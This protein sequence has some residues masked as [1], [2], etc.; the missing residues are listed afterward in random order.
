MFEG[1]LYRGAPRRLGGRFRLV[2]DVRC[3]ERYSE[4]KG[5]PVVVLVH[6]IGVSSRYLLPTAARLVPHCSVY[7][8]DLPGFGRSERLRRRPTVQRLARALDAWLEVSG[9]DRPDL[10][11]ANSFGCQL[12]VD[13]AVRRPERVARLVLVGP[14]IDRH[15]R[16]YL[17]QL[18]RLALDLPREPP[19]LLA[20]QAVDY[21]L[22]VAK[23]GVSGFAEML[24]DRMELKLPYVQA[25]TLV[26]RGAR[27]PIVSR[28]WAE[29]VAATLP[30]GRLEE[31][32]GVA[33]AVNYSA[34]DA[35]A[36]LTLSFM[37]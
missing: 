3:F 9:V 30:A 2:A 29:E 13:L 23:S 34:P 31:V 8:P 6:G 15:A 22:F 20:L 27:D 19:A 17:R 24:R 36:R 14:T 21:A 10:L 32:P 11:L 4:L 5:A 16:T 12:L 7:L 1:V 37:S 35:L 28:R 25:P 18:A 33:H 26:V